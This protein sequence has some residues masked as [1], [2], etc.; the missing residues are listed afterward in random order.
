MI[1]AIVFSKDRACQLD[2]FL[3]SV[4]KNVEKTLPIKW[5]VVYLATTSESQKGYEKLF[6]RAFHE[7]TFYDEKK[8]GFKQTTLNLLREESPYHVFFVDDDCFKCNWNPKDGCL[9][10]LKQKK[11]LLTVSLRM[12]PSYDFCYTQKRKT[13]PP[14]IGKDGIWKWKGL[15]GDWG[16]PMSLDGHIFRSQDILPLIRSIDFKNPNSLEARLAGRALEMSL[17]FCYSSAK[18]INLP[19]NRVQ[20]LNKNHAGLYHPT[21]IE[22]L[23]RR[24]L[25]REQLSLEAVMK[26]KGF[27][28]PHFEL[29]LVFET[30]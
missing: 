9:E 15:E 8:E 22:E 1:N 6:Q 17:I 12:D 25:S 27:N 3:R 7:C 29:P 18:I 11:D 4:E 21:S 5:S 10:L 2:C 19:V 23:N 13:P 24:F 30:T 16:Y 14:I 28:A 26:A 20:T